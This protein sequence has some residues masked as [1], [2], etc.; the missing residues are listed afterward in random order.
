MMEI[1]KDAVIQ[2]DLMTLDHN[3]IATQ[4]CTCQNVTFFNVTQG[5]YEL[6]YAI[7][8]Y[9]TFT[10]NVTVKIDSLESEIVTTSGPTVDYTASPVPML[11]SNPT[12]PEGSM[13]PQR[14]SEI[15]DSSVGSLHGTVYNDTNGNAEHDANDRT[16]SNIS[17][18]VTG[19]GGF[20]Y[21]TTTNSYGFWEVTNLKAGSYNIE[22]SLGLLFFSSS[23]SDGKITD[24]SITAGGSTTVDYFINGIIA[25]PNSATEITFTPT[26]APLTGTT[27]QSGPTTISTVT[28]IVKS[29]SST[30][31]M[32]PQP[33]VN[34]EIA[35]TKVPIL[36]PSVIPDRTTGNLSGTIYIDLNGNKVLDANEE[37][38]SNISVKVTNVL[39]GVLYET[40]T[41]I[42]G[43]W[44]VANIAAGTYS[45]E[46]TFSVDYV[47]SAPNDGKIP[48]VMI[49][50]GETTVLDYYLQRGTISGYVYTDNNSNGV[51]EVNEAGMAG[52]LVQ[53]YSA[54]DSVTRVCSTETDNSGMYTCGGLFLNQP[55]N[56]VVEVVSPTL[57]KYY[58][59]IKMN[60]TAGIAGPF[61]LSIA[62]PSVT[63]NVGIVLQTTP[64]EPK[65]STFLSTSIAPT[66]AVS[67]PK[68]YERA[69]IAPTSAVSSPKPYESTSI[70][71]TSAVSS[72][73]TYESASVTPTYSPPLVDGAIEGGLMKVN[74]VAVLSNSGLV[75][76]E[77][78]EDRE[79]SKAP[80]PTPTEQYTI[81]MGGIN[82]T[83]YKDIN[84]NGRKDDGEETLPGVPVK[85]VGSDGATYETATDS[86]GVW[87]IT[88]IK[89][90]TYDIEFSLGLE[91]LSSAP[92]GGKINS[93]T[94]TAGMITTVDYYLLLG[95][96]S[97]KV[98]VDE[99]GD[100]VMEG[101]EVGLVGIPIQISVAAGGL[102]LCSAT[103]DTSG[104]YSCSGL[105]TNQQYYVAIIAPSAPSVNYY[106]GPSVNRSTGIAGPVTMSLSIRMVTVNIGIVFQVSLP[107]S[108]SVISENS[109][110]S[111]LS[112]ADGALQ[113]NKL[114]IRKSNDIPG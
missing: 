78:P 10:R 30:L 56:V 17:V 87:K 68:P 11:M 82:G 43:F 34:S 1:I 9:G 52:A 89:G 26:Q 40:V 98:Y 31:F 36:P 6:S 100:G 19:D 5:T 20:S 66:S 51:Q 39:S 45:V 102:P 107:P 54:S 44:E 58:T 77:N 70:A 29:S 16:L 4:T 105:L 55:Y 86:S 101:S 22:I 14:V 46:F 94:V 110:P 21:E 32:K 50:A 35:A 24:V 76:P 71:P 72:P 81:A 67:S 28:P 13:M 15:N 27:S 41:D 104:M 84:G 103:T 18:K 61:T 114:I 93:V 37:T 59:G 53:I 95:T 23:N 42:N 38:L 96:I 74:P 90:G 112:P 49:A 8:G 3:L 91:Y 57:V 33:Q 60:S 12:V 108:P 62:T 106:T 109:L 80:V 97:G 47:S 92:Q 65:S 25:M 111:T 63:V 73:T 113:G 85:V 99:T 64:S 83:L 79:D 2:F 48:E 69:S 7:S 75:A 88:N